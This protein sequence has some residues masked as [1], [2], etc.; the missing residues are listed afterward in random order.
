MAERPKRPEK[1]LREYSEKTTRRMTDLD[2]AGLVL[3]KAPDR[4]RRQFMNYAF[5]KLD[6]AFRRLEP[7]EIEAAKDEFAAVVDKWAGREGFIVRTYSLVGFRADADFMIW[8]IAFDPAEF[9][10]M[11]RELNRTRLAGY[12]T[13]PYSYLSMQKRSIYVDRYNPEG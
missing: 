10:A 3:D 11:Q 12:L 6:P 9:Q 8:R 7:S 5:F 2:P 4:A 1:K 13:Q